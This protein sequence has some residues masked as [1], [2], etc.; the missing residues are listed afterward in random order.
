ME[1]TEVNSGE[2]TLCLG[3]ILG[4]LSFPRAHSQYDNII[5]H[6]TDDNRIKNKVIT[7]WIDLQ[8]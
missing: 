4:H 3:Q 8:S 7:T 5:L 2:A 6:I 1:N